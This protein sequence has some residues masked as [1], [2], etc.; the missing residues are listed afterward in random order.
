MKPYD[1]ILFFETKHPQGIQILKL[2]WSLSPETSSS[3]PPRSSSAP[4]GGAPA[5]IGAQFPGITK[6][7]QSTCKQGFLKDLPH[8]PDSLDIHPGVTL[9]FHDFPT[10]PRNAALT[11]H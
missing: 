9:M 8:N 5:S 4:M 6:T 11:H 10:T 1:Q 2:P 7:S 3:A